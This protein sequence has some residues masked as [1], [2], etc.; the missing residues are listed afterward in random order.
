L[1]PESNETKNKNH[2]KKIKIDKKGKRNKGILR[3]RKEGCITLHQYIK[4]QFIVLCIKKKK[5]RLN[6]YLYIKIS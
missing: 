1:E 4:E 5:R 2:F 6:I 3:S